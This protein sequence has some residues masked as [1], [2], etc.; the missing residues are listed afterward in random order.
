MGAV[1]HGEECVVCVCVGCSK[2]PESFIERNRYLVGELT[3][4]NTLLFFGNTL[5]FTQDTTLRAPLG[6]IMYITAEHVLTMG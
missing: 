1:Y 5:D 6:L 4:W 2:C 3:S